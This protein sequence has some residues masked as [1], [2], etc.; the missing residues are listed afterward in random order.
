MKNHFREYN[1]FSPNNLFTADMFLNYGREFALVIIEKLII[2]IE[3]VS[4]IEVSGPPEKDH[5]TEQCLT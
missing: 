4:K 3:Y 1:D 5:I 2:N